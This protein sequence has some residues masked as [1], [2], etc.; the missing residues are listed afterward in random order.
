[1]GTARANPFT[2]LGVKKL[3]IDFWVFPCDGLGVDFP[4]LYKFPAINDGSMRVFTDATGLL[5]LTRKVLLGNHLQ[6][7]DPG[8][9]FVA[10]RR[11]L[12]TSG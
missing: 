4:I 9:Y 3:D 2:V 12:R 8:Q 6:G 11:K 1:M 5:R 10:C 7:S